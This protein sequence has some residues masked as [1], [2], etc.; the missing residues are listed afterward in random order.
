[1]WKLTKDQV[2][3]I[4]VSGRCKNGVARNISK[5][6]AVK[7]GQNVDGDEEVSSGEGRGDKVRKLEVRSYDWEMSVTVVMAFHNW[8]AREKMVKWLCSIVENS[9]ELPQLL[10][11]CSRR[12]SNMESDPWRLALEQWFLKSG[13]WPLGNILDMQILSCLKTTAVEP[14]LFNIKLCGMGG[15]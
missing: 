2:V 14:E 11:P 7:N 13:P 1:M 3:Q 12:G 9:S 4:Q 5:G 6:W 15:D 8:V 10:E